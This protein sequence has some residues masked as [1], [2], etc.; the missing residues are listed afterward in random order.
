LLPLLWCYR[1]LD[2]SDSKL[3][4]RTTTITT[5][6][7]PHFSAEEITTSLSRL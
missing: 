2:Y 5:W 6:H 7:L 1:M 4:Y 3:H